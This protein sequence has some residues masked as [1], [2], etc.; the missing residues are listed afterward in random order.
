MVAPPRWIVSNHIFNGA[1]LV[2]SSE[3]AGHPVEALEDQ[4]RGYFWR[5]ATGWT[6]TEHNRYIDFNRGGV[7]VATVALGTYTTGASL[8]AAIVTAMEAADASPVWA[9]DY[10]VAATDKFRIRDA[11]GAPVN[12]SLLWQSGANAYRSIGRSLGFSVLADDSGTSSYTADGVSYQSTHHLV[13]TLTAAQVSSGVT[14]A[15]VIGHNVPSDLPTVDRVHRL[16]SSATNVWSSPTTQA[17]FWTSGLPPDSRAYFSNPAHTYYRLVVDDV[18]SS[19]GYY[20]LGC[21]ILG[22]YYTTPY[23]VSDNRTDGYDDFS[24]Q[25]LAISG[26]NYVTFRDKRPTYQ[27]EIAEVPEASSVFVQMRV[28]VFDAINAGQHILLDIDPTLGASTQY[29]LLYGYLPQMP[30]Y[31]YVPAGYWNVNFP[32]A[33]A[34]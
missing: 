4:Q 15:A 10:N 3:S 34:L 32:F 21:L 28:S 29:T 30:S 24:T 5:T 26:A 22:A 31:T 11:A 12:F 17:N 33:K 23:C 18:E 25:N 1:T 14:G 16:E 8:G 9:C 20:Q 6:I 27:F 13:I 7:K 19:T 2:P